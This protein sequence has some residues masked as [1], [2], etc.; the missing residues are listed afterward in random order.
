MNYEKPQK[1]NPHQLT[2]NQHCFPASCI[3]RFVGSDGK[4]ELMQ[5][6]QFVTIPAKPEAKIFCAKRAWDQ[7]AE[8]DFMKEI[9]DKYK[10]LADEVVTNNQLVLNENQQSIVTDM[11][12]LWNIRVHRKHQPI[13]DQQIMNAIG[14]AVEYTKDDQERLEKNGITAIRPNL[15]VP[16]RNLTGISI[17]MNFFAVR[18][19]MRDAHW[20]ILKSSKG[21]FIVPD[22]SPN[23]RILPLTPTLCFFSQSE[24]D[25]I[26]ET[27]LA[28]INAL[29]ISGS[30]EYYFARDLSKCPKYK[31][32]N[33]KMNRTGDAG[34]LLE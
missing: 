23:S 15:K 5:L 18:D 30:K 10:A 8:H 27:E 4:V 33:K 19:Q 16:G 28:K 2:V 14:V 32:Y 17:Q 12:A 13:Q 24:N 31:K 21:E 25:T 29:S 9:E 6:S 1:G 34:A 22:Q 3:K 7:K 20:G 11:F 26:D